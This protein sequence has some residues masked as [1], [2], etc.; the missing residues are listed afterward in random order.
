MIKR[1]PVFSLA[2]RICLAVGV[3][4]LLAGCIGDAVAL[5]TARTSPTRTSKPTNPPPAPTV[6]ALASAA[7]LG[8]VV[9]KDLQVVQ[10]EPG[11]AADKAG[12]KKGDFIRSVNDQTV[13]SPLDARRAFYSRNL[14]QKT[15]LVVVRAGR[16]RN[17]DIKP[18]VSKGKPGAPTP[19]PVPDEAVYF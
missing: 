16:V 14:S 17:F 8:I 4:L 19:T 9:D 2:A 7:V 11:G 13:N 18:G 3:C 6:V 15:H 1:F 12:V 10:V 5:P